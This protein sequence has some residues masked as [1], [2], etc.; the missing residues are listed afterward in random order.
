LRCDA[1]ITF[2]FANVFQSKSETRILS[3]NDADFT[4]STLAYYSKKSKVIQID[5]ESQI[6]S[7]KRRLNSTTF[8]CVDDRLALRVA[9]LKQPPSWAGSDKN[10]ASER[11]GLVRIMMSA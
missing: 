8:I 1:L 4:E 5:Y 3:F 7:P 9:H 6:S 11:S 2:I 10:V